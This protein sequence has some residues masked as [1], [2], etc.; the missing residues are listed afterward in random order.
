MLDVTKLWDK[1]YLF[2][3]S[4]TSFTRSEHIFFWT[5]VVFLV[6]G[7]AAKIVVWYTEAGRPKKVLFGRFF[8]LFLTS[9]LL[10][11]LWYGARV[12]QVP[13][14]SA[15]ISALLVFVVFFVWLV[16]IVSFFWRKYRKLEESWSEQKIKQK[17]LAR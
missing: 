16:F 14:I 15:H 12:E 9:G 11:M 10:L 5:A 6:L 13:W 3:P 17:Y 1:T 4:F 2:S 7:V 8:H